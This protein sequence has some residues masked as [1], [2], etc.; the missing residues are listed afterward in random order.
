M[1]RHP[2]PSRLLAL[3]SLL[4]FALAGAHPAWAQI[5]INERIEVAPQSS[6]LPSSN[7]AST[8][9]DCG[10]NWFIDLTTT[11]YADFIASR[12]PNRPDPTPDDI[13]S[14]SQ[15]AVEVRKYDGSRFVISYIHG[16]GILVFDRVADLITGVRRYYYNIY[17][18][19]LY[20]P[21]KTQEGEFL[22]VQFPGDN[23]A[24]YSS[25]VVNGAGVNMRIWAQ[26][27]GQ[28]NTGSSKKKYWLDVTP[29]PGTIAPV[30]IAL[31]SDSSKSKIL[32]NIGQ[33]ITPCGTP[34]V[35]PPHPIASQPI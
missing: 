24:G 17:I 29:T 5:E 1:S 16:G 31:P 26:A 9:D 13:A 33:E 30:S 25:F 21:Y 19:K 11:T 27:G 35:S 18:D 23:G 22:F 4:L 14:A 2:R 6:P 32:L 28:A 7:V 12:D 3:L 34:A 20:I 10:T 15:G 8:T